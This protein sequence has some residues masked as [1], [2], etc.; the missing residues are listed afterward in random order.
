LESIKD[1]TNAESTFRRLERFVVDGM[2]RQ[3]VPGVALAVHYQGRE[4]LSGFGVTNV[5]H[6]LPVEPDTLFQIGSISKTICA[7]A[8]M[9]LVDDGALDLDAPVRVYLPELRLADEDVAARVTLRHVFTHT[10]GWLGDFFEHTGSGEDALARVTARLASLPQLTPLGALYSYSNS[11]FYVAGRAIEVVTGHPYE[12]A[13]RRLVLRP[14]GMTMSFFRHFPAEF[15]THRIAAGHSLQED[16]LTVVRPWA[17]TRSAAPSGGVV[18]TARDVLRYAHFHLGDGT[19]PDGTRLLSVESIAA[20]QAPLVP[21]DG[22]GSA[23]GISWMLG[24]VGGIRIVRHGGSTFGQRAA[25]VL[26]PDHDFAISLLTNAES[27]EA[28]HREVTRWA[29]ECYLGAADPE[30]A[31]LRLAPEQLAAY[32]GRYRGALGDLD[33]TILDAGLTMRGIPPNGDPPDRSIRLGCLAA[34]RFLATD[35]REAG[36]RAEFLRDETGALAWLRWGGRLHRKMTA[37]PT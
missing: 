18:S 8:A 36:Q 19:A 17:R 21:T 31:I 11:G 16:R 35:T 23:V 10:G 12:R 15:I 33:V 7:T 25:L 32:A 29:L 20:M 1:P 22:N 3:R 6:P 34:D 28:L 37:A 27:G 13:I 5:E 30:T 4:W 2:E 24:H 26:A 14:L 9:R